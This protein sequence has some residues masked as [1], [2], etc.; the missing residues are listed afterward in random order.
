MNFFE[1]AVN[2]F[3]ELLS[4][5]VISRKQTRI[6]SDK[7]NISRPSKIV[8]MDNSVGRGMFRFEAEMFVRDYS[9]S[10]FV[11]E[12]ETDEVMDARIKDR[13]E[14]M[15]TLIEAVSSNKV[16]SLIIAGAPGLGKSFRV[17]K[18]LNK[19]N[20]GEY[21]YVFHRGYLKATGLYRLLWENRF[22][23]Q[24]IVLDDLDGIFEDL[25]ALNILKAA[26]EMKSS[27]LVC[28]GSEKQFVDEDG[29]IIPRQFQYEGSVIF[30]TNI[31]FS[32]IAQGNSKHAAHLA[33]L[34]SR[35][36]VLD[37]KVKTKREFMCIIKHSI[38]DG[39]LREKGLTVSEENE[40]IDF[41]ENN[42]DRLKELSIRAAEKIAALFLMDKSD[43]KK[44]A[45]TVCLK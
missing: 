38:A 36:L 39:M 9:P 1:A 11:R 2:E 18:V 45:T 17:N 10:L 30:L 41:M 32:D 22:A 43:W 25:T 15:E 37:L 4:T 27:R 5:K 34:D 16:N 3:P 24:T 20:S 8:D 33:A 7:Y 26:L 13:Y 6:I 12:E 21:G 44:L 31:A 29:G 40:I 28:W 23:G 35:S 42:I 14:S 19:V